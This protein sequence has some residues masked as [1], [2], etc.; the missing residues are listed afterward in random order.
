M[1]RKSTGFILKRLSAREMDMTL[2]VF[3]QDFGKILL[4]A[5]GAQKITS[6]RL[7]ALDRL[8]IVRI[9]FIEKSS[10]LYLRTIDLMSNLQ[11]IKYD[12][13]TR[14][15]LLLVA[16]ILDGLLPIHQ[17]EQELFVRFKHYIRALSRDDVHEATLSFLRETL[18]ILGYAQH[19]TQI[20]FNE[21]FHTLEE[22]TQR[23]FHDRW[24]Q[25]GI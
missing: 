9:Q 14:M 18:S 17:P 13:T 5:K 25:L 1:Y 22:L 3:T 23:D 12:L 10:F 20:S 19:G 4:I 8:S 16:D 15:L 7:P 21:I 6:K 11:S 24:R 2:V